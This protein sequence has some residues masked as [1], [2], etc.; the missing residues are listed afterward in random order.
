MEL[1][2]APAVRLDHR[3]KF[4]SDLILGQKVRS[5]GQLQS[6]P[7]S[8][9]KDNLSE[10]QK[11]SQRESAATT[12]WQSTLQRQEKSPPDIYLFIY[13][14]FFLTLFSE[15]KGD[16]AHKDVGRS[17]SNSS[18][19]SADTLSSSSSG[20]RSG[21][22]LEEKSATIPLTQIGTEKEWDDTLKKYS[23]KDKKELRGHHH[24]LRLTGKAVVQENYFFFFIIILNMNSI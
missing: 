11:S 6:M 18:L 14:I 4:A 2:G 20:S 7:A 22:L 3:S 16:H 17:T 10:S 5:C 15:R 8:P 12:S 21:L 24:Q 9:S 23:S 19:A 1:L 13:F